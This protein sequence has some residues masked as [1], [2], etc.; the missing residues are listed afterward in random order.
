M[1][2]YFYFFDIVIPLLYD[3][4]ENGGSK[5]VNVIGGLKDDG[6]EFDVAS[7]VIEEKSFFFRIS[8]NGKLRDNGMSNWG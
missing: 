5:E 7:A 8:W 2:T 3:D 1:T 6:D 4:R